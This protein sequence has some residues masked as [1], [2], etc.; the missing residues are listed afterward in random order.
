MGSLAAGAAVL[1]IS[2]SERDSAAA[3]PPPTTP[4]KHVVVIF[5]ENIS[6]DHYFGTYPN[7]TQPGRRAAFTALPGTP[8]VNG[9]NHGLLTNNPNQDHPKRLDRNQALTC[10]QNHGYAPEQEAVRR[11][12]DGQVRPEHDGQRLHAEHDARPSSYGPTGIVMDY[13]DGNTVT[14]LWNLAQHFA[15]NDNSYS[16]Q[17]GPSTPGAINLICGQTNGADAHGGTSS[18]N[19]ANGTLSSATA[20][21]YYDQCSQP[22]DGDQRRTARPAG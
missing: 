20:S 11:R 12:P 21:P 22:H 10:D 15:L 3:P 7:A 9:L 4:I 13:Y 1:G 6:F 14:G 18:G 17:F 19:V 5:D 8:A 2:M 16:T